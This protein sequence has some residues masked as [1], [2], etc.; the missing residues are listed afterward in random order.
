M[1]LTFIFFLIILIPILIIHDKGYLKKKGEEK[2]I[3]EYFLD[4]ARGGK[5]E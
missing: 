3:R 5:D 4:K 2:E 1:N